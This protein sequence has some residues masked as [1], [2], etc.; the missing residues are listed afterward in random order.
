MADLG[1]RFRCPLG[2]DG[3]DVR[4]WRRPDLRHGEEIG[5]QTIDA[6]QLPAP[7]L[8]L[9]TIGALAFDGVQSDFHRVGRLLGACQD[10][11]RD[12]VPDRLRHR[13]RPVR[14]KDHI[15]DAQ[16]GDGHP[17]LG[18]CAG[19]V[20]AEDGRGA[21]RL[22]GCGAACQHA[23]LGDAPRPH[24]HEH[25]QDERELL[26]EHRHAERN[27]TQD[28]VQPRSTHQPIQQNRRQA[29]AD[30]DDCHDANELPCLQ[31]QAGW[32]RLDLLQRPSD[33]P[34]FR[35]R[36]GRAN[37]GAAT[38]TDDK[39]TG[40]NV[41]QIVATGSDGLR[42]GGAD[43]LAHRNRLPGQQ[44]FVD[45]EVLAGQHG[46]VRR[47]PIALGEHDDVAAR[48]FPAGN[49]ARLAVANDQRARAAEVA[50][51]FEHAF[52]AALLHDGDRHRQ[53]GESQ[54]QQSF[55]QVPEH[56]IDDATREQ[57]REHRL[58]DDLDDNTQQRP[59][60]RLGQL[61]VAFRGETRGRF[62]RGQALL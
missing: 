6:R 21:E 31:A 58:L 49:A 26:G 60:I 56:E 25:G 24:H 27:A 19:L 10:P 5:S 44:R 45:L 12:E 42:A 43:C 7:P 52:A 37:L 62:D 1:N 50:Q 20:R 28:A 61:V 2:G 53:A 8:G 38:P 46:C 34:E 54:E 57:Q 29:D 13:R 40:E 41:W 18:Q 30:A 59:A 4:I 36:S 22:D 48:D 32:L 11:G 23:R 14:P 47:N 9:G 35:A 55:L 39:G 51:G 16:F 17:V 15:A 3:L 33:P